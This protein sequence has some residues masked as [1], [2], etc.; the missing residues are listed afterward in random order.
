MVT[1]EAMIMVPEICGG[2]S[3]QAADYGPPRKPRKLRN[4]IRGAEIPVRRSRHAMD[5]SF[6]QLAPRSSRVNAVGAI[7]P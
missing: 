1:I 4:R 2:I 6:P 3:E 7:T 5:R